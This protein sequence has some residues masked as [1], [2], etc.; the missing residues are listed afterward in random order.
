MAGLDVLLFRYLVLKSPGRAAEI[1]TIVIRIDMK[2]SFSLPVSLKKNQTSIS[3][4]AT[5]PGTGQ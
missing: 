2:F 1:M 3:F 4:V 5:G